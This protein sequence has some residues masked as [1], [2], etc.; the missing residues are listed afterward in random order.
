MCTYNLCVCVYLCEGV[1][2]MKI[3]EGLYRLQGKSWGRS[4]ELEWEKKCN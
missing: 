4:A 3:E 2:R 1:E